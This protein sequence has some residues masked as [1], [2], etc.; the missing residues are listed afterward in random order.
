[1]FYKYTFPIYMYIFFKNIPSQIYYNKSSSK[2]T[3]VSYIPNNYL[4]NIIK[5]FKNDLFLSTSYV[6][7]A[8]AFDYY[9]NIN[10]LYNNHNS[11]LVYNVNIYNYLTNTRYLFLTN[12]SQYDNSVRSLDSIYL[13][14]N[15]VEREIGE[16]FG[17]FYKFKLDSRKL[18][19]DY[20]KQE[21][22]LLKTYPCEGYNEVFYSLLD[23]QV[24]FNKNE[25]V[26]L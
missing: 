15:W 11:G 9:K 24:I 2:N 5:L 22:P 4:Y 20:S 17:I 26:E 19:L 1:V 25:I 12:I 3:L 18:L 21:Y 14:L 23:N 8:T 16:M 6:S 7:E 13:N 10:F